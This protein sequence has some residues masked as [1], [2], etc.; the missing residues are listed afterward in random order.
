MKKIRV[1]ST[2]AKVQEAI[3]KHEEFRNSYFWQGNNK[4][5]RLNWNNNFTFKFDGKKYEINQSCYSSRKNVYYSMAIYVN[6]IKK[7]IRALK[8]IA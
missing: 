8:A 1:K 5:N 2:L 6:G 3:Q 4:S 7:D